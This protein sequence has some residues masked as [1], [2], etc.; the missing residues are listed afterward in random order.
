MDAGVFTIDE[1]E[2]GM[3]ASH[4]KIFTGEDVE[5]YG[6]LS[7]DMNPLHFDQAYAERTIFK[8]TIVHGML[9]AGLISTVLGT[10]LPGPGCIALG[11]NLRFRGPVRVGDTVTA[12]CTVREVVREKRR[13]VLDCVCKVRDNVVIE[14]EATVMPATRRG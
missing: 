10:K 3:S 14:G 9:T 4:S 8:G 6:A 13:V 12:T 1:L 7:G 11:V 5:A 2:P